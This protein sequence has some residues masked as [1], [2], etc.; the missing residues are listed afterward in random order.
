ML[1][2]AS[3]QEFVRA[4]GSGMTV[5]Q[6]PT[7]DEGTLSYFCFLRNFSVID[8]LIELG[9]HPCKVRKTELGHVQRYWL[10]SQG[11]R[12]NTKL[13]W[14][15]SSIDALRRRGFDVDG[16]E[17]HAGIEIIDDSLPEN[18]FLRD[19]MSEKNERDLDKDF[20]DL[21]LHDFYI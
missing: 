7:W 4:M 9:C 5:V 13:K 3:E 19:F 11:M 12:Q 16:I 21:I 6:H 2:K 20:V 18:Q 10:T 15:K 1:E 8:T 17:E 14:A